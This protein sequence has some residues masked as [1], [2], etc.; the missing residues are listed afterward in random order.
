MTHAFKSY[1][2]F[3]LWPNLLVLI[4]VGLLFKSTYIQTEASDIYKRIMPWDPGAL[5][6]SSRGYTSRMK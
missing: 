2:R 1:R 4:A 5:P 6:C 3:Y